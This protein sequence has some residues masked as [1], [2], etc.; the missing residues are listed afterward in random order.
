VVGC[1]IL[2]VHEH[3]REWLNLVTF[4]YD[5]EGHNINIDVQRLLFLI[6]HQESA[7]YLYMKEETA[8]LSENICRNQPL[9]L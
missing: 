4:R 8:D 9:L 7:P 2:K 6:H 1:W 3:L 5:P